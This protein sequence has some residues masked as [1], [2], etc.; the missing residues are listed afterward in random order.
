MIILF[1]GNVLA[2]P[3]LRTVIPGGPVAVGESFTIQY[4]WEDQEKIS[5]FR[6]ESFNGLTKVNGPISYMA[7]VPTASGT[8]QVQ[9]FVFTV[10]ANSTGM[11]NAPQAIA[12][13]KGRSILSSPAIIHIVSAKQALIYSDKEKLADGYLLKTGEDPYKKISENLFVRMTIDKNTCYVGEPVVA[14]YKLYSTLESRSDIIRNPGF[15]GFAVH[16]IVNLSDHIKSTEYINGKDFDVHVLRQVQLYPLQ[17]GELTIDG[18]EIRNRVRFSSEKEKEQDVAEG[19]LNSEEEGP[20]ANDEYESQ[21]NTAPLVIKVKPLI[22][23]E[24]PASFSGAVGKFQVSARLLKN[25]LA[26]NES[27]ILEVEIKGRGN[28]IQLSA[29]TIH[30]PQNIEG[31]E[32]VLVDSLNKH[33]VP[34]EG[35]RIFRYSFVS[36]TN[37]QYV[38]PAISFSYFEPDSGKYHTLRTLPLS[39]TI[40]DKDLAIERPSPIRGKG[41]KI[42]YWWI[43]LLALPFIY[44]LGKRGRKTTKIP[45]D[46]EVLIKKTDIDE[47][48]APGRE[49]L[50]V[51][52]SAIFIFIRNKMLEYLTREF[53]FHGN[54]SNKDELGRKLAERGIDK[55][56]VTELREILSVCETVIY[57]GVQPDHSADPLFENAIILLKKLEKGH[58]AYL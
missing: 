47:L 49:L 46:K 6:V 25:T 26:R 38:L 15:Y 43:L 42:K 51:P 53:Q 11:I 48:F 28:F 33:S 34:L 29:P 37:G 36:S 41:S 17:S 19:L 2:Q 1:A 54:I 27:G 31:F 18:M 20:A 57:T 58:S 50:L 35:K 23:K 5:N 52:G 24:R 10:L 22:E 55:N 16:D 30:W 4:I 7:A 56:L 13:Y 3:V 39:V 21:V 32:A 44:G 8:S 9:N 14:T 12:T 45:P 40:L